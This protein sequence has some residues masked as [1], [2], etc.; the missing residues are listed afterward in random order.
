[1]ETLGVLLTVVGLIISLIGGIW[2]LRVAFGQ[3][4]VWGLGCWFVPFVALI[5]VVMYWDE[6]SKPFLVLLAGT[7]LAIIGGYIGGMGAA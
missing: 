2:F 1:M 5:F 3:S 4:I 7:V 6:S